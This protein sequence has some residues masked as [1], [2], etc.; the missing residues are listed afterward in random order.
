[1]KWFL[2]CC[3]ALASSLAG[4]QSFPSS[5]KSEAPLE[6]APEPEVY[7]Q[8]HTIMYGVNFA[9]QYNKSPDQTCLKYKQLFEKGYWRAGWVLALHVKETNT[10]SCL[11]RADAM[12]ML[13][14]LESEKKINSE[15]IWITHNHLRL[16][17]QLQQATKNMGK[18]K[19]SVRYYKK[20]VTKLEA[21]NEEQL[22][23][24][25]ALKA[26]ATSINNH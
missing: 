17:Q 11:S 18:L 4:C 15:F 23:K 21:L 7:E 22:E 10:Q 6:V 3:C 8:E 14:T 2:L 20:K 25:E 19:R 24:L 26:I 5:M 16:L 12:M 1:M 9:S 13:E